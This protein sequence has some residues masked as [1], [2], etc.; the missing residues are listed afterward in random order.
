MCAA[1]C[2]ECSGAAVRG[3]GGPLGSALTIYALGLRLLVTQTLTIYAIVQDPVVIA[4]SDEFKWL[5]CAA[6]R[7]AHLH[8][9][10]RLWAQDQSLWAAPS[11]V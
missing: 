5:V 3:I 4:I 10:V 2:C 11:K 6:G 9:L 1:G 7:C 8:L